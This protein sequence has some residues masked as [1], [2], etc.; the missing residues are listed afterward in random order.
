MPPSTTQFE[1][2]IQLDQILEYQTKR[3]LEYHEKTNILWSCSGRV[4][5]IDAVLKFS[6]L[7]YQ[8][9]NEAVKLY[10]FLPHSTRYLRKIMWV[11]AQR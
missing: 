8:S 3:K 11:F 1:T 10:G 6:T 2:R 5:L 7:T 9:N 4:T